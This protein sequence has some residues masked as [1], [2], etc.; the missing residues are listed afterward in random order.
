M[1]ER[2]SPNSQHAFQHSNHF[3]PLVR[4]YRSLMSI[5]RLS[6]SSHRDLHSLMT[7]GWNAYQN[8]S[9]S[10]SNI[11]HNANNSQ[12]NLSIAAVHHFTAKHQTPELFPS[13][14]YLLSPI[15]NEDPTNT[16]KRKQSISNV[17]PVNPYSNPEK[18]MHFFSDTFLEAKQAR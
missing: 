1:H 5:Q 9:S 8:N 4:N 14:S 2:T 17:L 7:S 3:P 15:I 16:T 12:N 18:S 10:L 13:N 6:K 11:T